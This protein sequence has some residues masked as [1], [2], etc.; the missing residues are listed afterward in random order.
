MSLQS[1][2]LWT[3]LFKVGGVAVLWSASV[4]G[5]GSGTANLKS[6]TGHGTDEAEAEVMADKEK[7]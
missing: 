7:S 4:T 5:T 2:S 1:L 6:L 3:N